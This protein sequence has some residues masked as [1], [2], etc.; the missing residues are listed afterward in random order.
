MRRV[1][2]V[3]ISLFCAAVLGLAACGGNDKRVPHHQTFKTPTFI[4]HASL[5]FGAFHRFVFAPAHSGAFS[6]ST[7]AVKNA[8]HAAAFASNQLRLASGYAKKNPAEAALFPSLVVLADKMNGLSA[9]ILGPTAS[10][11]Q[12]QS[13]DQSLS[14]LNAAATA[15]GHHIPDATAA[16][17]A[18]AGGPHT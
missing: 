15:G 8:A 1:T 16:Q 6:S 9:V 14:R 7:T 13:I 3:L 12:I 4:R 2:L 17:I 18:A 10:L 5:A 11:P